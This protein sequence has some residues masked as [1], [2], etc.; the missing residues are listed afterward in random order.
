MDQVVVLC[1]ELLRLFGHQNVS[2]L[3]VGSR[4][5][6]VILGLLLEVEWLELEGLLDFL[7]LVVAC[8]HVLAL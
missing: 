3:E 1:S 8:L 6:S 5:G 4:L 7:G 2:I